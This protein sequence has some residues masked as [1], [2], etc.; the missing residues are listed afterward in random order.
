MG[1]PCLRREDS[2]A[3]RAGG[4]AEAAVATWFVL[5]FTKWRGGVLCS[6]VLDDNDND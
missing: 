3:L 5:L 6:E 2:A 4:T 1:N